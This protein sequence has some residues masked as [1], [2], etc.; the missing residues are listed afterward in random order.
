M[1]Q[2]HPQFKLHYIH[3]TSVAAAV[4]TE[5]DAG[6]IMATCSRGKHMWTVGNAPLVAGGAHVEQTDAW[7]WPEIIIR[8]ERGGVFVFTAH[9]RINGVAVV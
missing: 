9:E 8:P 6:R 1:R 5:S 7:R 3:H 2:A 4:A